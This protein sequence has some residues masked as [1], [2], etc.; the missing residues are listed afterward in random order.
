[1]LQAVPDLGNP[2]RVQAGRGAPGRTGGP[3][4]APLGSQR[5]ARGMPPAAGPPGQAT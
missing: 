3:P 5:Q 1:M 2:G 4:G